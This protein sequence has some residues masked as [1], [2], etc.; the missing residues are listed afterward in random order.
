MQIKINLG[1]VALEYE[2]PEDFFKSEIGNIMKTLSAHAAAVPP[3]KSHGPLAA[4]TSNG[5]GAK[6]GGSVPAHSTN[7]VAKLLDAKSGPDLIMAAVVKKIVVDGDETINRPT[8]TSEMRKASSY[9][10]RTY[11]NNL[12]KYL[13][14]L[15]KADRLRLVSDNTYGLPAKVRE[16]L[17]PRLSE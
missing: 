7:T 15:T 3:A 11:A 6:A 5:G 13:E 4:E 9:Y 16:E 8:I 14:T 10:K 12:S 1:A 17:E 2:G